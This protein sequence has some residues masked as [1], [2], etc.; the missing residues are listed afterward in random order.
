[1][2]KYFFIL[3]AI[4]LTLASCSKEE[5]EGGR[6]SI[7]GTIS[8]TEINTARAEITEITAVPGHE[9]KT[10]DFF[11]LNT[12]SP[13]TDYVIWF[14][15]TDNLAGAPIISGRTLIKIDYSSSGSSNIDIAVSIEAAINS[16][17]G[18][19]FTVSRTNDFLTITNSSTGYVND[20]D[21]AISKLIIDVNT[22]GRAETTL[23]SGAFADEDVYIIYGDDD[24]IYDDNIKTSFDGTFKFSNLRKGKYKIFAYSKDDNN[25]TEPLTPVFE[26]IEIGGNEDA[27]IGIITIEKK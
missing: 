9:I 21:N 2:I 16:I 25:I 14:R 11:L 6:S 15:N 17:S 26:E 4:T 7:S 18:T 12:P 3:S 23:Q 27:D 13:S 24:D 22:Q 8:G 19:P 10:Q 1:M 20:A 5:G